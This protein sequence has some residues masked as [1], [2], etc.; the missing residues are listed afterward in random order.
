MERWPTAG[1]LREVTTRYEQ[2]R[3]VLAAIVTFVILLN[4][5]RSTL[6]NHDTGLNYLNVLNFHNVLNYYTNFDYAKST[7][8]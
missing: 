4:F 3:I 7:L 8:L 2:L 6:Q 1:A 5:T